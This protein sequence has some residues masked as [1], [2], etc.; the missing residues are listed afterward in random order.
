MNKV[1]SLDC[2]YMGN[3]LANADLTGAQFRLQYTEEPLG[4]AS[5]WVDVTSYVTSL[6]PVTLKTLT[7]SKLLA[8]LKAGSFNL[9]LPTTAQAYRILAKCEACNDFSSSFEPV[10]SGSF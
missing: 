6:N 9:L 10:S 8:G 2:S 3:S 7:E 5:T 4:S 1:I